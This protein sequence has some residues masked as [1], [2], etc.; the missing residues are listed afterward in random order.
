MLIAGGICLAFLGLS[1]FIAGFWAISQFESVGRFQDV[2]SGIVEMNA[3]E[4]TIILVMQGVIAGSTFVLG[5]ILYYITYER[6]PVSV[7]SPRPIQDVLELLWPLMM[8]PVFLPALELIVEWNKGMQLPGFLHGLEQWAFDK[9][10]Q[11]DELTKQI[12]DF[13]S[14]GQF[15]L[16]MLVIALLTG[17]GEELLFRGTI[18]PLMFRATGNWH[19]AIWITAIIFSAIHVQFYGFVPRMLLGVLFGYLYWWSGNIWVPILGHFMN[20]GLTV[21][22]LYLHKTGAVAIDPDQMPDVPIPA[23]IASAAI[24]GLALWRFRERY[25]VRVKSEG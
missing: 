9:E 16:G 24:G 15:L 1:N 20:N 2:L 22:L 14:V 6:K 8:I 3:G 17:I 18:Q 5:P 12:T 13:S 21:A 19:A 23:I 25:F 4:R 10:R 11:L 7:V